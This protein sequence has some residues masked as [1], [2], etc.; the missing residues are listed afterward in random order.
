MD[1]VS[2]QSAMSR[3]IK[4]MLHY[5][6]PVLDSSVSPAWRLLRRPG[7]PQAT[8]NFAILHIIF[9][10]S[11][12][13]SKPNQVWK[14]LFISVLSIL[15]TWNI[16]KPILWNQHALNRPSNILAC[17]CKPPSNLA[18][19]DKP[20]MWPAAMCKSEWHTPQYFISINLGRQPGSVE[21][22]QK[23]CKEHR[24]RVFCM[25]TWCWY[26]VHISYDVHDIFFTSISIS[27]TIDWIKNPLIPEIYL[28]NTSRSLNSLLWSFI[29][30]N[31]HVSSLHPM[32]I[33]SMALLTWLCDELAG[34]K[35]VISGK[36]AADFQWWNLAAWN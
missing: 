33:V 32:Q 18:A 21:D 6:L 23:H 15:Y 34:W 7:S 3:Q 10:L 31:E 35:R 2:S 4:C 28:S 16:M 36:A 9:K 27:N 11:I 24:K 12:W 26:L 29:G 30:S 22:T 17:P 20:A 8:F 14:I 13:N 5:C 25:K 1:T 19:R